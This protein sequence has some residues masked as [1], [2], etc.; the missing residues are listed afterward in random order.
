MEQH[1]IYP[2]QPLPEPD[3]LFDPQGYPTVAALEYIKNWAIV[4]DE[5]F[6]A[7]F[8]EYFGKPEKIDDL[9][10]YIQSIWTYDKSVVYDGK[11]L[12]IHTGGWSG[13]EEI[14]YELKQ[15]SL[16]MFKLRCQSAGGHY[17]FNITDE[18][19]TWEVVKTKI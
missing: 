9:I 7:S 1:E 15:T 12:E 14:I 5:E 8:G 6:K 13:N 11:L 16:W 19:N 18:E 2:L 3:D 10:K 17:Y 4:R